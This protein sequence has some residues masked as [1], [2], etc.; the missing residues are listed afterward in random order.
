VALANILGANALFKRVE[1]E[2]IS[3]ESELR[4][5]GAVF[6]EEYLKEKPAK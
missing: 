5:L 1:R 4:K 6:L 2:M 3:V